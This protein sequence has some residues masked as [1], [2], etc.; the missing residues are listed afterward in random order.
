MAGAE[1]LGHV[2]NAKNVNKINSGWQRRKGQAPGRTHT[3]Q[4][5]E[6]AERT[7][8]NNGSRKNIILKRLTATYTCQM[9]KDNEQNGY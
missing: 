7:T 8:T 5:A 3:G 1:F 9:Q 6:G 2:E 4:K